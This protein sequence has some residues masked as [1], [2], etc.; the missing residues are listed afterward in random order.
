V[1]V[2]LIALVLPLGLDTFAVVAALGA[3]GTEP[4]RRLRTGHRRLTRFPPDPFH[5]SAGVS[6]TPEAAVEASPLGRIQQREAVLLSF[7]D[8]YLHRHRPGPPSRGKRHQSGVLDRQC[9]RRRCA[10]ALSGRCPLDR[11][12]D[13]G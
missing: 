4:T 1:I 13:H 8:E 9:Q 11:P 6:A 2:K 7:C 3:A 12:E 5:E 10:E